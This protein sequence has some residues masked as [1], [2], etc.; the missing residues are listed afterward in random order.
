MSDVADV[1]EIRRPLIGR[2]VLLLD[3][4]ANHVRILV[5]ALEV[6]DRHRKALGFR[7]TR[8]PPP[9]SRSE[10]NVAMPHLRGR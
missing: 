3:F 10:V 2:Q 4:E 1:E 9:P 5:A 7:D 8:P 6:V